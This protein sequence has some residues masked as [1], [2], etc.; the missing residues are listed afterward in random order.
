MKFRDILQSMLKG[1]SP[2]R[3]RT[4]LFEPF[5]ANADPHPALQHL[6]ITFTP[7][8]Y[9]AILA[10]Y[11]IRGVFISS[12]AREDFWGRLP[13][14]LLAR[15]PLCGATYTG[16]LDTHSLAGE[17]V[18]SAD[19]H[20]SVYDDYRQHIGCKH[21]VAVQTFINLNGF[22]PSELNFY[23]VELD[24]PFIMPVFV[25]D[26]IPSFA[27]I[28]SLPICRIENNTFVPRYAV[29]MITYYS[30]WP[31]T[32]WRRRR[33]DPED[34]EKAAADPEYRAAALYAS[35]QVERQ[36]ELF[37]LRLW[38]SRKKLQWLDPTQ[39]DLPL[40]AEPPEEIPYANVQGYLKP[41]TVRAGKLKVDFH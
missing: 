1:L 30:A 11:S 13:E 18:T 5:L 17:W 20:S 24:V 2:R 16:V 38:V 29:Y 26:D 3:V 41:F 10:K 14:Y 21:F 9:Q 6:R 32:L 7:D 22:L 8:E 15:C 39:P 34:A 36:P 27:V 25:P 19:I 40:K 35:W 23:H 4:P 37:D 28:H 12:N 31:Q 33:A